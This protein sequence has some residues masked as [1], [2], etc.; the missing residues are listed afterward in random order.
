MF[1]FDDGFSDLAKIKVAYIGNLSNFI[2]VS[3]NGVEFISIDNKSNDEVNEAL[4]GADVVFIVAGKRTETVAALSKEIGALTIA[5]VDSDNLSNS[6][7]DTFFIIDSVQKSV[8]PNVIKAIADLIAVP[9]LVNL[10]FADVKSVL[11]NSGR[12]YVGTGEAVGKNAIV[13]AVKEAIINVGDISK[14][15]SLMLNI[16]GSVDSL[17]MMEV[18]EASIT[19]QESV[20]EDA[21][22]IW[23]VSVDESFGDKI[24][25]T[26]IATNLAD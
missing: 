9:G 5:I 25:A 21:E 22:I 15:R 24:R 10:D 12:G 1:E 2:D 3:I 8:I 7:V 18:N 13:N 23:G 20:H 11:G 6:A 17:S 16:L 4:K 14:S 26:L 19:L